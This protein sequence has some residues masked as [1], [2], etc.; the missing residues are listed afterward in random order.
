MRCPC[1]RS[2]RLCD[3]IEEKPPALLRAWGWRRCR[4]NRTCN[5]RRNASGSLPFRQSGKR[6]A[7]PCWRILEPDN[8]SLRRTSEGSKGGSTASPPH[9]R[10]CK[11]LSSSVTDTAGT[12]SRNGR[13]P[14]SARKGRPWRGETRHCLDTKGKVEARSCGRLLGREVVILPMKNP[15]RRLRPAG[16]SFEPRGVN[17]VLPAPPCGRAL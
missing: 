5:R 11:P 13:K 6:S 15:F 1:C 16:L 14:R 4:I 9:D 7:R 3:R 2:K 8:A 10:F 17:R 12:F